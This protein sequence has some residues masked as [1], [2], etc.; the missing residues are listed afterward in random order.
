MGVFWKLA[1]QWGAEPAFEYCASPPNGLSL[2]AAMGSGKLNV[3]EP[4][5]NSHSDLDSQ[6]P[7]PRR[8]EDFE[9]Y[10]QKVTGALGVPDQIAHLG[11]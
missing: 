7:A 6:Q 3:P 1:V 9:D 4:E 11:T 5:A 8:S 2:A 10:L